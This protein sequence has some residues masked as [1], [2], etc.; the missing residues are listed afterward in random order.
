VFIAEESRVQVD[1][2]SA[3]S[4]GEIVYVFPKD[5]WRNRQF[6][7]EKY[8]IEAAQH[9]ERMGFDPDR[10][11]FCITGTIFGVCLAFAAAATKYG[12][13]RVLMFKGMSQGYVMR[14][15][16]PAILEAAIWN[17]ETV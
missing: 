2:S 8:A 7:P 12:R 17:K 13:L 10:D 11:Y 4:F 15:F 16:D 3:K 5:A 9:L 6:D 1:V 14:E